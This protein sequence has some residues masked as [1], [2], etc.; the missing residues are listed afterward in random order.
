MEP[1]EELGVGGE[2]QQ[3]A[4]RLTPAAVQT[5]RGRVEAHR[6]TLG[7]RRAARLFRLVHSI[8]FILLI[9]KII[10]FR[11]YRYIH[12]QRVHR[13]IIQMHGVAVQGIN[14]RRS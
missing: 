7:A 14:R 5:E 8:R 13:V 9:I 4:G 2:L 6:E 11:Q 12:V 3:G 10:Y 1:Q